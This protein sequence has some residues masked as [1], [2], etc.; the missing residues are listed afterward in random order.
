MKRS[1]TFTKLWLIAT[2]IV[3]GF[4]LLIWIGF[5]FFSFLFFDNPNTSIF[6]AIILWVLYPIISVNSSIVSWIFYKKQKNRFATLITSLPLCAIIIIA[7]WVYNDF[8]QEPPIETKTEFGIN[9]LTIQSYKKIFISGYLDMNDNT[10]NGSFY[11]VIVNSDTLIKKIKFTSKIISSTYF[12]SSPDSTIIG[13]TDIYEPT[14]LLA[15][16]D[17]STSESWTENTNQYYENEKSVLGKKLKEKLQQ[18]YQDRLL[19]STK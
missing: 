17:F 14:M 9:N 1:S 7:I 18:F 13:I 11:T 10:K 5:V 4:F 3:Y 15:I 16:Y 8:F 12:L 2:Q 6:N 19:L